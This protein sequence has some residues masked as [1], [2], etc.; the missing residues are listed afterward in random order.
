MLNSKST[1]SPTNQCEQTTTTPAT[2]TAKKHSRRLSHDE[3]DVIG[4]L[5][6]QYG[7]YQFYMTFLL[8]LF[9]V[10]NTF[11][12]SSPVYQVSIYSYS[13]YIVYCT[14]YAYIYIVQDNSLFCDY[15]A[16]KKTVISSQIIIIPGKLMQMC[17]R[18]YYVF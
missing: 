9:Q 17:T 7:K 12:I 13:S 4:D 11:H 1:L 16:K 14:P 10:P 6:G 18:L 2:T 8:S 15:L 3:C 5:I